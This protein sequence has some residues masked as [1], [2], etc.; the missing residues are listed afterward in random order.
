MASESAWHRRD[1]LRIIRRII[2]RCYRTLK[3]GITHEEIQERLLRDAKAEKL[4]GAQ[5]LSSEAINIVAWWGSVY[6]QLENGRK[7]VSKWKPLLCEFRKVT[8]QGKVAYIPRT[9]RAT[10]KPHI[11]AT[12]S[13]KSQV[14]RQGTDA[15][16]LNVLTDPEEI[17]RAYDEFSKHLKAG[18][19]RFRRQKVTWPNRNKLLDVF[20][21]EKEHFWV[22][23]APRMVQNRY[24]IGL[25]NEKPIGRG[26]VEVRCEINPPKRGINR[27]CAGIFLKDL[28]GNTYLAHSG[29]VGGGKPGIG[30]QRF[31][32]FYRG[33]TVPILWSGAETTAA[34]NVIVI[35]RVAEKT[36]LHNLA[37]LLADV[38]SFKNENEEA[39]LSTIAKTE[40]GKGTFD[41]ANSKDARKRNEIAI[42][43]RQGQPQF[44]R[45]LLAEYGR[46]CAI[47]KCDCEHALEA[48]HIFPYRGDDTNHVTNGLLLRSDL[49]TLFDLH[50]IGVSDRYRLVVSDE[51]EGTSYASLQD[52]K[53]HLPMNSN[54][55]PSIKAL[56]THRQKML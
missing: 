30:K 2:R 1:V 12:N 44:R 8:I 29:K 14:L 32:S 17:T 9:L 53:L 18:A 40:D 21:H 10:Q 27:R 11:K 45:Q 47:T 55:W 19:Q 36:F 5:T 7:Q 6:T 13:T 50:L 4:I 51:L 49:H 20:W 41:P 42:V 28:R 34:S 31:I 23:F 22:T 39:Q 48:A 24:W 46:R 54:H 43:I 37:Q 15:P 3:R 33:R 16:T 35:G 52:K 25:G 56:A 26:T 38:D